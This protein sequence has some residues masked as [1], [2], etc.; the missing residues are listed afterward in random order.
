[1]FTEKFSIPRE[2]VFFLFASESREIPQATITP[3]KYDGDLN[4]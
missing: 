4:S 1:M 2:V 3:D